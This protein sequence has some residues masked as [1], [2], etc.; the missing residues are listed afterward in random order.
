[1]DV[2]A[3]KIIL[4]SS[5]DKGLYMNVKALIVFFGYFKKQ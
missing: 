3:L 5:R 4:P 1:M 2:K